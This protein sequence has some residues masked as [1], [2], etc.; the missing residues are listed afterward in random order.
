MSPEVRELQA[1]IA[2]LEAQRALLGDAVVDASL[3]GLRARLAAL[4]PSLAPAEPDQQLKQVSI[5]FLDVVGSTTLAQRLDPE[6]VSAVMDDALTRGTAIVQAHQGRV[7]QYAGDNILAAFG[8][9]R[10]REDDAERAVS[11]GL[12][13]LALG[14]T[15]GAEVLATHG[16]EGFGVRVGIH[17][18]GVLLGG[19]V[20]A[21]GTIR[22]I[23]VNVAARME[24]TAPAGALRISHETQA[25]VRGLFELEAQ[26]PLAVKGVD[27]PVRSYL[28][29]RAKPRAARVRLRGIESVATRMVGRDAELQRLQQA[30]QRL[31]DQRRLVAVTVVAEAGV[32]KS[33]L[34]DEFEAWCAAGPERVLLLRGRATPDTGLQAF[35]L[36]R[37]IL[38][39]RLQIQD[40]DSVEQARRKMEAG[41]VPL[42]VDEDGAEAA[43][44]HAHLLGHLIGIDWKDSR[45][46]RGILDDPKELRSRALHAAAQWVRRSSAHEGGIPIVL[47]LE[48]L[49]WADPESLDFLDQLCEH[50]QDVPMLLLAFTRPALFERRHGWRSNEGMHQRI[51]LA[52]LGRDDSLR[53]AHELLKK[54]R[55][56]PAALADLLIQSA[57][58]NPFYM[59]ELV[60]MLIDQGVIQTSSD[61]WTV[62]TLRLNLSRLPG[63]LTGVLQ[64]RL[65]GLP[66]P[67]KRA[68]QEASVAGAV[69]W[70]RAL[71][72][73][74][75]RSAALLPALARRALTLPRAEVAPEGMH[76]YA[77][78][79]QLLHQVTYDTVLK[80]ARREGHARVARWLAGLGEQG[81]L[82]A[83]DMLGLAA[84]HYERAEDRANAAE[85]HA[86]AAE[87]ANARLA[88]ERVLSH[89]ARA[90]SLLGPEP[91]QQPE[92]RWRLLCARE[93][94]L[95]LLA[96]RAEQGADLDALAQ[97]AEVLDDDQRRASVALLRSVRAM[98]MA[99]WTVTRQAA[100]ECLEC[101]TRAG[102]NTLRL[103]AQRMLASVMV[104][105]GEPESGQALA[106]RALAEAQQLGL[107]ACESPLVT[108][109]AVAADM[110]G[111]RV[112][113]V[114]LYRHSLQLS[115]ARG[116][117]T[118]EAINLL[119]LGVGLMGLGDLVQAQSELEAALQMLRSN[120]D[121]SME[122]V[123]S[124]Q[125]S[126]L[127]RWQGDAP[128]A[129]EMAV[130]GLEMSR[131]A[132]APDYEVL[133][134]IRLGEAELAL[135]RVA[136]ARHT[137]EQ[138]RQR[139]LAIRCRWQHD[140]DAGFARAALAAG[141][142]AAALAVLQPL[143]D[144]APSIQP[145]AASGDPQQV[146]FTCY[147]ALAAAGDARAAQWLDRAYRA[148][149]SKAGAISDEAMRQRFLHNVPFHREI[150]AAWAG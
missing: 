102:D 17:T 86:R 138:A 146:E 104:W 12:A 63:T 27:T 94:A 116:S 20:D 21:E 148:V 45:H 10:T 140:A 93:H 127:L 103:N 23:A 72:A 67:E 76:E 118:S 50:S 39:S 129:L 80:R 115:R 18:G 1:G 51:D 120:G 54:L 124:S 113:A 96:K 139:A 32:G 7:L 40:D 6:A 122:S 107:V 137:L 57:E 59:E 68:L 25:Q 89:V 101:A 58:G 150:V 97:L 133:A 123:A 2:A 62:D 144:L 22:G 55:E 88:H 74:D 69:F 29:L 70:D 43:Q 11:C 5:L 49:H 109:L 73:I 24:Q 87:H 99:D 56:V 92:L 100:Q 147:Q 61:A 117:R 110:R 81:G 98:R 132:R 44:A 36:L 95:G 121:R 128:R 46:I 66:P 126:A 8:A 28:V 134:G 111:D 77:F 141:D 4:D 3:A 136:E 130:S 65:D 85:F 79:H 145:L 131:A 41:V 75:S 34:R 112:A 125:L 16:H 42:F 83:G 48:D 84:E 30:F 53:L 119:N 52:P 38:A 82:R 15:L 47:Q 91:A 149:E 78:H 60:R 90:L 19:G 35:G 143:L 106:H 114:S 9:D 37:D 135:G 13:L 14:R 26:A 142:T 108:T 33:R 31:V 105:Q 71:G 64:A